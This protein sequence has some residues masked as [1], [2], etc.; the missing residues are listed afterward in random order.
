[1]IYHLSLK[2]AGQITGILLLLLG[3]AGLVAPDSVSNFARALP[4]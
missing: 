1:M 3:L 2:T 4:R